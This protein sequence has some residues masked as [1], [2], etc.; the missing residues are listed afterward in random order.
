MRSKDTLAAWASLAGA[1]MLVGSSVVA[2]KLMILELPVG[3]ASL[4]RFCL[5]GLILVPLLFWR[6][7]WPRLSLRSHAILALMSLCGSF[8]FTV[9]LLHGLRFTSPVSAG[10]IASTTPAAVA[11]LGWALFRERPGRL[12]LVGV[13]LCALGAM[14]TQAGTHVGGGGAA[15]WLGNLLVFAAVLFESA[16]LLLRKAVPERL[17]PLGTSTLASLWGLIWFLGLGLFDATR[18]DLAL[19]N[20][21]GW[22]AVG[23]YGLFVTVGAYLL[24]FAGITKVRAA[25]AGAFTALMPVSAL[26]LAALILGERVGP[27]Q[28]AGCVLVFGGILLLSRP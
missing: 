6:E 17:S 1:Q 23:Y 27:G 13:A 9:C 24:W 26:L 25:T 12:A 16:F 21:M 4:L 11:L 28:A 7:G 22:W 2:G 19:V 5:A 20:P 14:L 10:I 15:P 18:V 3:L 8:L